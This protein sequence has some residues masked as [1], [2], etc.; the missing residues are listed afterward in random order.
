MVKGVDLAA[1][2]DFVGGFGE[3]E[4]SRSVRMSWSMDFKRE[5]IEGMRRGAD[6]N[7]IKGNR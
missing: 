6:M 1:V 2:V 4:R 7:D 5:M 3:D